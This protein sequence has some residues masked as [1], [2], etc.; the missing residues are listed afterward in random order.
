MKT[1]CFLFL[2]LLFLASCSN[3]TVNLGIDNPTSVMISMYVDSLYVEVPPTEIVWVEMGK[4]RHTIR[5]VDTNFAFDFS[6]DEYLVNPTRSEYLL[7]GENLGSPGPDVPKPPSRKVNY[8][9]C[10]LD[11][12]YEVLGNII[13]PVKWEYGP[14]QDIS[15]EQYTDDDPRIVY[16]LYDINDFE[17]KLLSQ[18]EQMGDDMFREPEP[19]GHADSFDMLDSIIKPDTTITHLD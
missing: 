15:A 7:S 4:G 6:Q 19:M 10:P 3:R 2:I 5:L 12:N 14:R 9:G 1:S 16:K 13:I 18:Y 17:N 8:T 11:G